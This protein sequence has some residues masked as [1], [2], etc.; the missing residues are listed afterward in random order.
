MWALFCCSPSS[1]SSYFYYRGGKKRSRNSPI[2]SSVSKDESSWHE[3]RGDGITKLCRRKEERERQTGNT[4]FFLL[5]PLPFPLH[6]LRGNRA[7]FDWQVR[8]SPNEL[9]NTKSSNIFEESLTVWPFLFHSVGE[10]LPNNT[11]EVYGT[12]HLCRLDSSAAYTCVERID[13]FGSER[14]AAIMEGGISFSSFLG[15]AEDTTVYLPPP[16][17]LPLLGN[18]LSGEPWKR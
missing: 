5:P 17:L 6:I 8:D 15:A 7:D 13:L 12:L 4:W 9:S 14:R 2:S 3:E 10:S 18:F 1:S 16:R 11:G